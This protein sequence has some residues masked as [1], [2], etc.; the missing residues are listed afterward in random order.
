MALLTS[1]GAH[2]ARFNTKRF[3]RDI[4]AARLARGW[5]LREVLRR[6]GMNM[7][8]ICALE[9]G[10][11]TPHAHSMAKLVQLYELDAA[12]YFPMRFGV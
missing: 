11:N 3:A 4:K 10:H 9:H 12:D 1:N 2:T 6:T 5:S 7:P 8:S